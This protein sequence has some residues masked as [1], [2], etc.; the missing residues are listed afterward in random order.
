MR[1]AG[2]QELEG[3]SIA[4]YSGA[5][6]SD[7]VASAKKGNCRAESVSVI[8][9]QIIWRSTYPV[10]THL[11]VPEDRPV[12]RRM[13][14][15]V[16]ARSSH[17]PSIRIAIIDDSYAWEMGEKCRIQVTIVFPQVLFSHKSLRRL[18][19]TFLSTVPPVST[20]LPRKSY[21]QRRR[22]IRRQ[23]QIGAVMALT[24]HALWPRLSR[25]A[26]GCH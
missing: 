3:W 7:D 14:G 20:G 16:I 8:W 6:L 18:Y 17:R 1:R 15:S 9:L 5:W 12:Q 19:P 11:L 22:Q 26:P 21:A 13:A 4:T 2:E 24:G 23:S 25:L 10:S